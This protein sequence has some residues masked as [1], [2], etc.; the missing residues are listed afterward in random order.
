MTSP[1]LDRAPWLEV[2]DELRRIRADGAR[3][4]EELWDAIDEIRTHL[5]NG[6]RPHGGEREAGA[7]AK[8]SA[9]GRLRPAAYRH[10][11]R[12]LR[13]FVASALPDGGRVAVVSRGDTELLDLPGVVAEHFPRRP[14]GDYT[15]FYPRDGLAAV[16]HFEWVRAEGAEYMLFPDTALW[17]LDKF[18]LLTDHLRARCPEVAA[19]Q[20]VGILF[21]LQ[22]GGRGA[23]E[24][25]ERLRDLLDAWGEHTG[26]APAILDW[27]TGLELASRL[28]GRTVFT[29]P[30]REA[31]LPYLD[32]TVD[33]VAIADDAPL[34]VA[35]ARRVARRTLVRVRGRDAGDAGN[36]GRSLG[37]VDLVMEHRASRPPSLPSA[38]VVVPTFDG[39]RQL[40]PCVRALS[41]SLPPGFNGEVLVVDDASGPQ[42]AATLER[43]ARAHSWLRVLRNERNEGFIAS[44]NRGA[45]GARGDFLVFL[46][47]DTVPLSGWLGSLLRTF[48]THPDAGAV[49]GRL[50]YPDGRL[51]EAG[52][53]VYHDGTGANFG[54]GDYEVDAPLYAHVRRVDYCSGALLATPRKLFLELGGFDVRYRPAYYEDTD[55][56]F[57]VRRAGLEVYYQPEAVVVHVEGATSGTDPEAGVKRYQERN[58]RTFCRKWREELR[59]HRPPP[60]AYS[61]GTWHRLALQ[62]GWR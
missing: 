42:T 4:E 30:R 19:E 49:G 26:S 58:R 46:N 54:R 18:P 8:T 52:G 9:N 20:G 50:V 27:A 34:V 35:E 21:D 55:Y 1:P 39:V 2:M 13:R 6:K 44:C 51:Q 56:C 16:A 40:L 22:E 5:A 11:K 59:A 38:T 41:R 12:R 15:G 60:G 62:G 17:W 31:P 10:L 28:P 36:G 24:W 7:G 29:P 3:R 25:P 37:E 45:A 48:R 32:G 33:V 57:S 14:G 43:L 23:D 47:D 53:L 61:S